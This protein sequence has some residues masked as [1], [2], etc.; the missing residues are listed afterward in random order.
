MKKWYKRSLAAVL[1]LTAAYALWLAGYKFHKSPDNIPSKSVMLTCWKDRGEHDALDR[2]EGYPREMLIMIWQE[3]DQSLFGFYGDIWST[4]EG[5]LIVYYDEDSKIR[6]LRCRLPESD[7][8]VSQN[9]YNGTITDILTESED[10]KVSSNVL[11]VKTHRGEILYFTL[12]EESEI[13]GSL[14]VSREVS[15]TCEEYSYAGYLPVISIT[16]V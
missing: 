10:P 16:A 14:A 13:T 1:L 15:I 3:P 9:I 11:E 7:P 2:L 12:V 5:D 6:D 4:D 8:I